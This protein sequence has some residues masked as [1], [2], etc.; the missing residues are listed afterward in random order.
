[1][2]APKH[3]LSQIMEEMDRIQ[4]HARQ[5]AHQRELH[6]EE[7]AELAFFRIVRDSLVLWLESRTFVRTVD[8]INWQAQGSEARRPGFKALVS[9]DHPTE[10][11][12]ELEITITRGD[13]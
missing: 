1:M 13:N 12:M 11:V 4:D 7:L 9:V 8:T 6:R 2:K 3:R 5:Q 10:G